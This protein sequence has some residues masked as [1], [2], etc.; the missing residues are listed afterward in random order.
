MLQL[1]IDHLQGFQLRWENETYININ[2]HPCEICSA[3]TYKM[4]QQGVN[5]FIYL[6]SVFIV[7]M[8]DAKI[9]FNMGI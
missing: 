3:K 6:K 8:C 9:E 7:S 2:K 4:W 5:K 1:K